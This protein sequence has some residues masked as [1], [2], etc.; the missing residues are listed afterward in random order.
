M[1]SK[2]ILCNFAAS[3]FSAFVLRI[4]QGLEIW[5]DNGKK[6][7]SP[8]IKTTNLMK[9]VLLLWLILLAMGIGVFA[10]NTVTITI[11]D[12]TVSTGTY[13]VPFDNFYQYTWT[14]TIYPASEITAA[15][16]I[17]SIAYQVSTAPSNADMFSTV[18]IYMGT[19]TASENESN[20]SW[21]PAE[22]L[23]EVYSANN[24][25]L[26]TA[27][28]WQVI[29]LNQPFLYDGSENLVIV[30]SK[31]MAEYNSGLKYKYT[32]ATNASL[33]RQSDTDVGFANHPGTG[34][35]FR[36][37]YRPNLKLTINVITDFCYAVTDLAVS[38]LTATNATI[39]WTGNQSALNYILQY[40]T[41][42][43]SWDSAMTVNVY[44]TTFDM[45]GLLTAS[46]DYN[47]RVA[48]NCGNDTSSWKSLAF[49]TPCEP[50]SSLPFT[51]NFDTC[52]GYTATSSSTNNLPFCW[53][54]LNSGTNTNYSGYP[55][56]YANSTYAASGSNSLR[57]Y[58]YTTSGNYDDQMVI[59]P[60]INLSVFSLNTLQLSFDARKNPTYNFSLVVGII[61]NPL[62][63]TTFV[64]ID[65]ITSI[66]NTFT[67]YEFLFNHY[68]GPAGRIAIMAPRPASGY[69]SGYI[70]NI[71]V[72]LIP[73]CPKP[74]NLTATGAT[75]SSIDLSW[76]EMG[77]A[78]TWEIEYG[79]AGFT[80][81]TGTVETAT[82]NPYTITGLNSSTMYDFYVRANC[83]GSDISDYS[84]VCTYGTDCA[85][86]EMPYTENFDLYDGN[87]STT[88]AVSNLPYCWNRINS[89][90]N[91]SYSGFPYIYSSSTYAAS[92]DNSIRFYTYTPSSYSSQVLV[93]PE[94]DVTALPMNTLQLSFDA[95]QNSNH[96][97]TLVVGVMSD[98]TNINTFVAVDT[99]ATASEDYHH[100]EFPFSH[101]TGSGNYVA[102]MVPKP[103]SGYNSGYVDNIMLDVLP[104]CIIPTH[105]TASNVTTTSIDLSWEE[106][107]SATSWDIEYGPM[108]FTPGHG[109]TVTVTSNPYTVTG[110]SHSTGYDFY[111]R[112]NCG[113]GDVSSYT[114]RFYASTACVTL[115]LPYIETFDTYD[116][117][118]NSAVEN[119]PYCWS[120]INTGTSYAGLPVIYR[121][122]T[123]AASG[124]NSLRFYTSSTSAYND[125]I[126]VL[127]QIDV[128]TNPINTLQLVMDVS[129]YATTAPF[130]LTVGVMTDPTDM[131]TF[132]P[133]DTITT[134]STTYASYT[135]DFST[136]TG[137]GSYIALMAKKSSSNY[138][139]GQVDNL[140]LE[141]NSNCARPTVLTATS[142]LT[143][144]VQLSWTDNSASQWEVLYGPTG[145]D[146]ANAG[147]L[148]TG[149]TSTTHTIT[150]LTAGMIY[151]FYVRAN[152]G[153]GHLSGWTLFPAIASP[154][155]YTMGITGSDTVTACGILITDD[156]GSGGNYSNDCQYTLVL[157]PGVVDSVVSISGTFAGENTLDYLS[158][159]DGTT[160]NETHLLQK[161]VSGTTGNVVT[162]GPLTSTSGP[163][164]LLFHSNGS[165]VRDGFAAF[166]SCVEAP[167][168]P[169]PFNVQAS[170]IHSSDVTISWD[171]ND[172]N[173]FNV[174]YSTNPNFDPDTCTNVL[175]TNINSI[176]LNSLTPFTNYYVAVQSDCGGL[177]S[178]W[179]NEIS[180]L[181]PCEPLATLP[182]MENFDNITGSTSTIVPVTN[183]PY[184]WNN[185][186]NGTSTSYSGYPMVHANA[187]YAESGINAMCFYVYSTIGSYDDQIAVLPLINPTLFPVNT[188]QLT[189]DARAYSNSSTYSFTLV[190]GVLSNPSDKST[191]VP[192]DTFD[193]STITSY[194]TFELPL[195]LYQGTGNYIAFM[196]PQPASGYNYGYVDNVVVNLMPSCPKPINFSATDVTDNSIELTWTEIG[197][198]TSWEVVYGPAGFTPGDTNSTVATATSV[199]YTLSNLSPS[200]T[201]D[202]Y[203]R[204]NCSTE[205]S[206]YTP[207]IIVT[208]TCAPITSLPFEE[209][210]D[211]Y[212]TG[213]T[214]YIDCW[215]RINNYPYGN[216]PYIT[217]THY[218]GVG[219]LSFYANPNQ[220]NVA[221]TPR[222]DASIPINTLQ[223][224]FMYRATNS[225]DYLT[226]GVISDPADIN[227][228]VAVDTIYPSDPASTWVERVV[229]FSTYSGTGQHIA[230]YNGNY[231]S[232]CYAY[233]DNL[234]IDLIPT[235][236]KPQDL[237]VMDVT[238]NS[239]EL[240][241]TETGV[242]TSWEIAYGA[243]GFDLEDTSAATFVTATSNPFTVNNLNET[244]T[245]QFYVR[246]LCSSAD[247]STWSNSIS[248]A[249]TL[250]PISLPYTASFG[251]NDVWMLNNGSC[252]NY[253][254][255][256]T[257]NNT[258]ALFVTNNGI[259]PN[260]TI[261]ASSVVS[262]EKLITVGTSD[263]VTITFD[264]A[265]Q[266]E[267]NFDYLKLFLAPD[268][269]QFPSSTSA[270][271]S[272]NYAH[273]SYATNA[274]NF[275]ENGYGTNS[276]YPCIMNM[277]T[278]TVHVMAKMPNPNA[279][280]N[281]SSTA[282][283]VFAWKNDDGV[284]TQPPAT[285][286][287]L[288]VTAGVP[289]NPTVT[290]DAA[291]DLTQT[292]ATLNA[293]IMN[294]D[295]V[296]ITAKG[297]EWKTTAGG[298]YTLVTGTGTGDTFT[299]ALSN[300]TPST[301]YTYK[302][303]ITFNGTTVY[304]NE[305]TFVT[306]PDMSEQ[307]DAP[308]G[309]HVET[310]ASG[311]QTNMILWDDN[312]E[313]SQWNVQYKTANTDWTTET[314]NTNYYQI[315]NILYNELYSVRVQAIC[316]GNTTSDWT[317]TVNLTVLCGLEDHLQHYVNL[318]PNPAK[319]Y[320]DIRVDG[321]LNV[322]GM[323]VYDV[324]G[325]R[326]NTTG[327]FGTP[328]LT[329]INVSDLASGLYFVRVTTDRGIVT[330]TFVKGY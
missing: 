118:S 214:V 253:W 257:V 202:I 93:L 142:T 228:F 74:K 290:T 149:V 195:S 243:P 68:S 152:C 169:K 226:V 121:N 270:P 292:T 42:V 71:L 117:S 232:A 274:Y 163:L 56:V 178:D 295:N 258:G 324:Y 244:T 48:S 172:V 266:G 58:T 217:S 115:S 190:V 34:S 122:E 127:P 29:Q 84:A 308:T 6:L 273:N 162:F 128:V 11:G 234:S 211:S 147:T 64:P 70:D 96:I 227:T 288:T 210:F 328:A 294:P 291:T 79:P 28:G 326:I 111:V 137:S 182:F 200:T 311:E 268:S 18:H 177:F 280:P 262:A 91:S 32:S 256:G 41:A 263:T 15:G 272:G 219:S 77:S 100:Y 224:T 119:L 126:A 206:Q 46:T 173:S 303:F 92:G 73:S 112:S 189:F 123:Y 159:Y 261:T 85:I 204:S 230:F 53:E 83:G 160:V 139:Y 99:I 299:A 318:Y 264:V 35:G 315:L 222:F 216:R 248:G 60:E 59:L 233:M 298:D 300:L 265:V 146:P 278:G 90:S 72:D 50:I 201:Y 95:R 279:N 144:A 215:D 260:Y 155:T 282:L 325:K 81:G 330:K 151:D 47:V 129:D 218:A 286:T 138:N 133:V 329:R 176:L 307:C 269:A 184:C 44:D 49:T 223:A 281:A 203:V 105:V 221:I 247:I 320:V 235:C 250:Q 302:A 284:G 207:D 297:F 322:T 75:S 98:P 19:T 145:F 131:T 21:L 208:T 113:G 87:T 148:V 125:Q 156:G 82:S 166:V 22:D 187:T 57:F 106:M 305:E 296:A 124:I 277:A 317:D 255:T 86:S 181:T 237:H 30:I 245:Y 194:Q 141:V 314:V 104:S 108:G 313:V 241:W 38:G 101:Y 199:P 3:Y 89:G 80:Q 170:A 198:A 102:I 65:T 316:D 10:Q 249:T 185:I 209:G 179:S 66:P 183:L 9:K 327:I 167:T 43:Q 94:I 242:A 304:G 27:V 40:K 306:L 107:G 63:K 168:C 76:T 12:T 319:E 161:I 259:S 252:I 175:T 51:E 16:M 134:S 239:I 67:N 120:R 135:V 45:I 301:S 154:Y 196:A 20:S 23:T 33:Y 14:Q 312:D 114:H 191:F 193:L 150:G 132:T 130:N 31:T 24:M 186:N 140:I 271:G 61:S 136:Y 251:T 39:N 116:A 212:G 287:N 13:S 97:L 4:S 2:Y 229:N 254:A 109:T 7:R 78:S 55:I 246:A 36:G 69:N 236:P 143:D 180:F 153:G 88:T 310:N 25:P 8:K 231:T 188:L 213:T 197:S 283:L 192:V 157:Y 158:V 309:L 275:Y 285:I 276:T 54:R 26:P 37:N 165:V 52:E 321:D 289:T 205:Y 323:E 17:T 164:T 110:L 267:S 171:D 174:A 238:S 1:L 293:D 62:D 220:H 5:Y 240:G 103:T 225:T